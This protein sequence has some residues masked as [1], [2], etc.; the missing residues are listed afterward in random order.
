MISWA[1]FPSAV[2]TTRTGER[3]PVRDSGQVAEFRDGEGLVPVRSGR[4]SG[5][6]WAFQP[7]E[8]VGE[9]RRRDEGQTGECSDHHNGG[10]L[11]ERVRAG[12]VRFHDAQRTAIRQGCGVAPLR[13]EGE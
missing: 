4:N 5:E 11:I 9:G 2:W 1:R 8:V 6:D 7:V 12:I 13:A 3:I 10:L